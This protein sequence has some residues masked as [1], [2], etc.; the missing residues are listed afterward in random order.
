MERN[1]LVDYLN[2]YLRIDDIEDYGPQGLQVDS[3]NSTITR[4]ALAVDTAPGP[5]QA[6]A[7]TR[8]FCG[9]QLRP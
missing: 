7:A 1:E 9:Q 8:G 6:A 5:I 3:G 4:V 2:S